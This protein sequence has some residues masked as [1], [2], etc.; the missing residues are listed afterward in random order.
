MGFGKS[1]LKAREK[2]CEIITSIKENREK[3]RAE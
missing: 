1:N 3:V 2:R